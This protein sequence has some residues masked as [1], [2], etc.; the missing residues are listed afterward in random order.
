[1][2]APARQARTRAATAGTSTGAM[3]STRTSPPIPTGRSYSAMAATGSV[4][5]TCTGCVGRAL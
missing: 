2:S 4:V 5:S 3:V 1:M